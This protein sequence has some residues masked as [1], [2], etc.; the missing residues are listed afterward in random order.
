MKEK[1]ENNNN[2]GFTYEKYKK[3]IEEYSPFDL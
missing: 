2:S 1:Y 3:R